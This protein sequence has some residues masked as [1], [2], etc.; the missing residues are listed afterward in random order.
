MAGG[1]FSCEEPAR[2]GSLV[3]VAHTVSLKKAI[4][5]ILMLARYGL[6][7]GRY[8]KSEG[9]VLTASQTDRLAMRTGILK[10]GTTDDREQSSTSGVVRGM[11]KVV[12]CEGDEE[13]D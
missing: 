4:D 12:E 2:V 1:A 7:C 6:D 3:C 10:V 5:G 9:E 13:L 11:G 8:P